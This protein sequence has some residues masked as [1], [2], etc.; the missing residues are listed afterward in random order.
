M[1]RTVKRVP[2][3]FGWPL[4][5]IWKGYINPHAG[6]KKCKNCNGTGYNEKTLI[7][8]NAHDDFANLGVQWCHNITQDEVMALVIKGRL[9]EFTH[10]I[11]PTTR[12][13]VQKTWEHGG[14]LCECNIPVPRLSADHDKTAFCHR[15]N[16]NMQFLDGNDIRLQAPF[17]EE[18]NVWSRHDMGHDAMVKARAKR[19]GVYG[20]CPH[21]HGTGER[22]LSRRKKKAY[23]GWSVYEPPTGIG[24]QLWETTSKGSPDSPV[25]ETAEEL[26]AWC[27]QY[28]TT[29][30]SYKASKAQWFKMFTDKDMPVELGTTLAIVDGQRDAIVNIMN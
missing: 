11:D 1:G 29:F 5:K 17:A 2:L 15:C 4:G 16:R 30:A 23:N 9:M 19:L 12:R 24:W 6:P 25:F 3:N 26:A 22:K 10:F 20:H 28:A 27:E 18:V 7:L 21:C 13:W 8:A 14:Y